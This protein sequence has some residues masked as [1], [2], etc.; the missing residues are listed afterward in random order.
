M[1]S[2]KR[3]SGIAVLALTLVLLTAFAAVLASRSGERSAG[4]WAGVLFLPA[5]EV[6]ESPELQ[7]LPGLVVW[8]D[9]KSPARSAGLTKGD[10]IVAVDGVPATDLDGLRE[11]R[12]QKGPRSTLVYEVASARGRE[13][14]TVLLAPTP[15]PK[16]LYGFAVTVATG[17]VFLLTGAYVFQAA[18]SRAGAWIFY[19]MCALA[20]TGFFVEA[21]EVDLLDLSGFEPFAASPLWWTVLASYLVQIVVLTNLLLHY[22]LIYPSERPVVSRRPRVFL[23]LHGLALWPLGVLAAGI[24]AVGRVPVS[25]LLLL[26]MGAGVLLVYLIVVVLVYSAL[27]CGAFYRGYREGGADEKRQILWPLWGTAVSF[28]LVVLLAVLGFV[29]ALFSPVPGIPAW[30]MEPG[31][32]FYVLIPVSFA[33]GFL[34]RRLEA[35]EGILEETVIYGGAAGIVVLAWLMAV[36][37]LAFALVRRPDLPGR[38]IAAVATVVLAAFYFPLRGVVQGWVERRRRG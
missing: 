17:L 28:G 5:F 12:R 7:G 6:G 24:L 3:S 18:S 27:T 36:V 9:P 22:S 20:A 35:V 32:I 11:L 30:A 14:L 34:K 37:P 8:L 38:A 10:T 21:L 26:A 15:Q 31:R 16:S 2:S 1:W 13:R 25:W 4:G 23:W 19:L 29:V 33:L